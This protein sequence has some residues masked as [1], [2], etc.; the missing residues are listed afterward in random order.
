MSMASLGN[1]SGT[2]FTRIKVELREMGFAPVGSKF[3]SVSGHRYQTYM[4]PTHVDQVFLAREDDGNARIRIALTPSVAIDGEYNWSVFRD[5]QLKPAF[6][7]GSEQF[8]IV[9][10]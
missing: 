1:M 7:D 2:A 10:N 5:T 9:L 6:A 3:T 8:P 4:R